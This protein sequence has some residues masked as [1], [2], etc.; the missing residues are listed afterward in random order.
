MTTLIGGHAVLDTVDDST[1]RTLYRWHSALGTNETR[2]SGL[3]G[4]LS[5]LFDLEV[6][7][8]EVFRAMKHGFDDLPLILLLLNRLHESIE[9]ATNTPRSRRLRWV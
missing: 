2:I 8:I 1:L 5:I 4:P 6:I 9:S 7:K 3:D